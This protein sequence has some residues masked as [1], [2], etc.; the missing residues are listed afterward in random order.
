MG[1]CFANVEHLKQKVAEAPYSIKINEFENCFEQWKN[2]LKR[3]ISSN[4][5]YFEGE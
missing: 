3:H 4:G 2:N 1:K 5:E